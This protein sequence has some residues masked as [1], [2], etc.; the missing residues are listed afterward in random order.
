VVIRALLVGFAIAVSS[1]STGCSR[2]PTEP[3]Q[4]EPNRLTVDNQS[5]QNWT[6]VEIWLNTYYRI[7]T[8]SIPAGGRFQVGLDSFVAG[9][10]QRFDYHRM[11]VNDLRLIAKLPDGRLFEMKKQ[12]TAGGLA[13]TISDLTKSSAGRI[14]QRGLGA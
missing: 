8:P 5:S 3:L 12:F 1:L 14:Q 7:T 11:Q 4:L 2:P 9:F 13:G 6:G 10:G